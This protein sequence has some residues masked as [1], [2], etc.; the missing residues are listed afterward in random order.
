MHHLQ[1]VYGNQSTHVMNEAM[2]PSPI[3]PYGLQKLIGEQY[4]TVFAP[5]FGLSTVSLRYFNVYGPRQGTESAYRMVVPHFISLRRKKQPLTV[6]G[7]GLQTRTYTYVGDV[8]RATILAAQADVGKVNLILNIGSLEETSVLD[9]AQAIGGPIQ[10]IYPN[11]RGKYEEPRKSA[12]F[13]K[14]KLALGWKP[15]VS[16]P[17]GLS[18]I[19]HTTESA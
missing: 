2:V 6:Y 15:V 4:C 14:A 19:L 13:T 7:D 18:K 9:I 8:V 5:L 11:P 1:S 17:E 16:F 12:N 10:H 3:S